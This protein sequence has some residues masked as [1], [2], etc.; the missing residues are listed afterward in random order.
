MTQEVVYQK[1]VNEEDGFKDP[2]QPSL[3]TELHD[4]VSAFLNNDD[5]AGMASTP[6]F[7]VWTPFAPETSPITSTSNNFPITS[8]MPIL[9]E[10]QFHSGHQ[11]LHIPASQ[12]PPPVSALGNMLLQSTQCLP[13]GN[14]HTPLQEVSM[15][16]P[17][18]TSHLLHQPMP[19]QKL[20]LRSANC[21]AFH[22]LNQI[23]S[24]A[25]SETKQNYFCGKMPLKA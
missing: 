25:T 11:D 24:R 18:F 9:T 1:A 17:R 10:P 5:T 2:Q 21:I 7:P 13:Q 23:H 3:P 8:A 22:R 12:V 20:S 4:V 14:Q 15:E 6:D 16:T 19:L